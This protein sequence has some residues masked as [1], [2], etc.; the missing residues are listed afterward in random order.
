MSEFKIIDSAIGYVS[1]DNTT[2]RK[3]TSLKFRIVETGPGTNR[4]N[5]LCVRPNGREYVCRTAMSR[6]AAMRAAHKELEDGHEVEL[7][8]EGP[9][10]RM[11]LGRRPDENCCTVNACGRRI[12]A[13]ETDLRL[14]R[15]HNTITRWLHRE[16]W[17]KNLVPIGRGNQ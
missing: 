14:M 8:L 16:D 4:F 13:M 2:V 7:T 3:L 15:W 6:A 1:V 12:I 17:Q 9:H 5:L 11:W 10:R